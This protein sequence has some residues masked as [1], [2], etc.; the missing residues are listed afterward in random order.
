MASGNDGD[1]QSA[2]VPEPGTLLL[3]GT[4]L[5]GVALTARGRRRK[6]AR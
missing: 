4:G 2:P 6:S 1:P 3:V 5:V